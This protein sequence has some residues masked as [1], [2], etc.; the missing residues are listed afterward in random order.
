M[1]DV[2]NVH[3]LYVGT[4]AYDLRKVVTWFPHNSDVTKVLV[5]FQGMAN[6]PVTLDK[7]TFEAAKQASVTAGG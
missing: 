7:T 4:T 6:T 3:V 2:S 1:A 5:R